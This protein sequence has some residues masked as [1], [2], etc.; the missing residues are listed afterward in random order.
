MFLALDA[1][2]TS[3]RAALI[4]PGGRCLGYGRAGGGNPTSAGIENA[5]AAA[6]Q[7]AEQALSGTDR[8]LE[9]LTPAVIAMAGEKTAAFREQI[10]AR[11]AALGIGPV[12]LEPDL[13]GIFGSGTHLPNGYAMVAGTGTAAVRVV[14]GRLDQVAGGRG[15]LLGDAGG[16]YWIG[17]QVVRAV[18]AA[19]DGQGPP[20]V[21]TERLLATLQ[22]TD[23]TDSSA[24]RTQVL[25]QLVST[26]YAWRPVQ[27]S[28]FAPLA[29]AVPDDPVARDILVAAS[30]ALTNLLSAVH[31]PGLAG[32]VVV[33]GSVLIHGLLAA[34]AGVQ[35]VPPADMGGV[36]PVAD[37]V[38]GAAVLVLRNAGIEVDQTLFDTLRDG[39]VARSV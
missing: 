25:R 19:L 17:H 32:P 11:L 21:L 8:A 7:A 26:L 18:V 3:T 34:P 22:M 5:V 31:D 24:G 2:G 15:W 37:G 16:G 33:G 23:T 4:D 12:L 38:V 10:A 13:L 28:R 35:F 27:L 14:E 20:T 39:I 1:G 30:A 6:G 36:V 9:G 29:F